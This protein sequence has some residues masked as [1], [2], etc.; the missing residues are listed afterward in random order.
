MKK[1]LLLG[2]RNKRD[3]LQ[4]AFFFN[5]HCCSE[6]TPTF[7]PLSQASSA[8]ILPSFLPLVKCYHMLHPPCSAASVS[9]CAD[10]SSSHSSTHLHQFHNGHQICQGDL[11]PNDKSLV[12]QKPLLKLLQGSGQPLH[13]LLEL[14]RGQWLPCEEG[15]QHLRREGT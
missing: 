14:L 8:E 9:P 4:T 6:P 11:T 3:P 5:F 1:R 12:L 7:S 2:M 10:T 15:N 13:N